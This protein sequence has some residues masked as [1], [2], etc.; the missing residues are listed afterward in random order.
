MNLSTAVTEPTILPT[1]VGQWRAIYWEPVMAT[2]ERIC[3]GF[4][5]TWDRQSKAVLTVRPDLLSTLFGAAG[6]KAHALLERALRITSARLAEVPAIDTAEP[7]MTGLHFG[8]VETSHVNSLVDL[9]RIGKLMSSSLATMAEPDYPEAADAM[10]AG[11]E[12]SQPARQFAT[13]VRDLVL[14]RNARLAGCF[15]KEAAL[16]AARRPVRFGF[17]S[18]SLV[19]QFG[20][21]QPTRINSHVR[22]ARGLIAEL[23]LAKRAGGRSNLLILGFPPLASATLTDKERSAIADYTEDLGLEAREF[24][25]GFAAADSDAQACDALLAAI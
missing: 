16:M 20:L 5:T 13:R 23:S 22:L 18:D 1:T 3:I 17:L 24:D 14:E 6:A 2:G 7:P 8:S 9:I 4:L 15:N 19:A 21:L 11:G 10:D 12:Q 25:V